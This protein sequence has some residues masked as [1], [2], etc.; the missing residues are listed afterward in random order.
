M[1][2]WFIECLSLGFNL[3]AVSDGGSATSEE[4]VGGPATSE[5]V[6]VT[7]S[8]TIVRPAGYAS[9]PVSPAGSSPSSL[10]PLSGELVTLRSLFFVLRFFRRKTIN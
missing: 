3:V 10:S 9:P 2:G 8:I 6:K 1:V 5:S 7:R 4:G